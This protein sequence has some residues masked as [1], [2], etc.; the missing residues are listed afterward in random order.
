MRRPAARMT[1]KEPRRFRRMT[2]SN[3]SPEYVEQRLA[4]VDGRRADQHVELRPGGDRAR[5]PGLVGDVER[6]SPRR[7]SRGRA[8]ASAVDRAASATSATVTIGAV[9]GEAPGALGA[10]P[11]AAADHQG[12]PAGRGRTGPVGRCSSRH[13]LLR[14]RLVLFHAGGDHVEARARSRRPRCRS[15][16]PSPA[17]R[18]SSIPVEARNSS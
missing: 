14:E 6:R 9:V 7:R 4:H 5:R 15:P 8:M 1:W 16:S 18:R 2:R 10:D 11:G 12:A 3:S 13:R 17:M